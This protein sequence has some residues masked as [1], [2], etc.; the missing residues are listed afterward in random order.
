M[1][2]H[3]SLRG[4]SGGLPTYSVLDRSIWW[5][6]EMNGKPLALTQ[7]CFGKKWHKLGIVSLKDPMVD[8]RLGTWEEVAAKYNIPST[9][10]KHTLLLLRLWVIG[11]Q[12][13]L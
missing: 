7:S 9:P 8:N 10:K 3:I 1:R 12:A 6:V 4:A 2:S 13:T 5:G 11:F